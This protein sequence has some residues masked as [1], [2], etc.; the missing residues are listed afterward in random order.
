LNGP[1][2]VEEH[3]TDIG[4]LR[5][6]DSHAERG[7]Q[8]SIGQISVSVEKD[9]GALVAFGGAQSNP[10]SLISPSPKVK[11]E[12][13]RRMAIN[14]AVKGKP[15]FVVNG[16]HGIDRDTAV[17]DVG[18]EVSAKEEV[19]ILLRSCFGESIGM[20][21]RIERADHGRVFGAVR[22]KESRA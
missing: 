3:G 6:S 22:D 15:S 1:V 18:I 20:Q 19:R 8:V 21:K 11:I 16:A 5:V 17:F 9:V 14:P 10:L 4:F 2:G 13:D 7:V 12:G